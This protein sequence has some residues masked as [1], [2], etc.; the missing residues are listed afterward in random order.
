MMASKNPHGNSIYDLLIDIIFNLSPY[1]AERLYSELL[2]K[3]T[4][5]A[6]TK[7]YNKDGEED[8][9]NGKIR[10]LKSQYQALRTSFGDSYIKK[11][12]TELTNYIEFLEK[13]VA[14]NSNYKQKLKKY[15]TETH[16]LLLTEGWVYEKCK[17]YIVKD[18]P[19]ININPFMIEDFNTA[20][21][22]IRTIPEEMRKSID[23]Q[24]LI[25]K[26]PELVDVPYERGI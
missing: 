18:R 15:T 10:L 2:P 22:Y 11:A 23:V 26:F 20:L 1:Q 17:Q 21:E 24:M 12:F 16:N 9:V 7:L 25:T 19:K 8:S 4:K 14:T 6:R 5:R 13:N 3:Y